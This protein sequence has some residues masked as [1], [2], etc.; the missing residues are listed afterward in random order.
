MTAN[1]FLELAEKK[2]FFQNSP[3]QTD[4]ESMTIHQTEILPSV[5]MEYIWALVSFRIVLIPLFDHLQN[6]NCGNFLIIWKK[7]ML[8]QCEITYRQYRNNQWLH[9]AC[10]PSKQVTNAPAASAAHQQSIW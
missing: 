7:W 2:C 5:S 1:S 8:G 4:K 10:A 9:L 3:E 6:D